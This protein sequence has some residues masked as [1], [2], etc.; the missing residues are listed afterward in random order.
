MNKTLIVLLLSLIIPFTGFPQKQVP[1]KQVDTTRLFLEVYMPKDLNPLQKYPAIIFFFGGGWN[2]GSTAQF[3]PQARY[4]S[5]RGLVSFLVDYRV[6]SRNNTSPFES[7]KDAK[8]AIRFIR[9]HADE[10]HIDPTKIIASG[11]SAGGHLAAASAT[12]TDYND[13]N[14][15]LSVSCIPQALVLFNPV[16]DNGPG[17]YGYERIDEAYKSFSPLHNLKS[18]APPTIFFLGTSDHLIPVETGKYYQKVMEQVNSRC[19]LHLYEDQKHGF[20]NYRNFEFYKDTLT[21]ADQF[22]QSLG[23][24][25]ETPVV[26]I[27]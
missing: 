17:G 18:G 22:L 15:N 11:G 14:D 12:I 24:L 7:L 26:K 1:Y 20:F 8:S 10:F 25:E 13:P 16:I 6:K 23:Y 27:E 9:E 2:G 4:F 21:K 19:D 3:E 5:E